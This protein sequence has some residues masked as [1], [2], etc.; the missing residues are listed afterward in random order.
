MVERRKTDNMV[1]VKVSRDF[2][3]PLETVFNAWVDAKNLGNW[4]FGTPD[5][6][7][8]ISKVDARV[9]GDFTIGERRGDE[10]A[11]HIGTF[12]EIDRGKRIVFSFYM[13]T[14]N[15]DVHN[16][17]PSNVII[18][19]EETEMGC[20]VFVTHEMD[21]IWAEY[22]AQAINGWNMIFDGLGKQLN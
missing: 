7:D 4:L 14:P 10:M 11:I 6:I 20:R 21:R 22:E 19:F 18:D 13:E 1:S 3:L 2:D 17:M 15:D 9:G 5:G 12:H 16:D 8:K